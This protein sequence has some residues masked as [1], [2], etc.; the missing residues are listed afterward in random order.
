MSADNGIYILQTRDGYRVVHAQAIE[1]IYDGDKFNLIWIAE[2]WGKCNL[3]KTE[4]EAWG[5]AKKL[6]DEIMDDDFCPIIEYG[7]QFIEGMENQ[8]F[9]IHLIREEE[10][11]GCE[12]LY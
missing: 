12:D 5:E 3:L 11:N 1:N 6:Y 4:Q 8:D 7:V 9:P 10:E 2:Y